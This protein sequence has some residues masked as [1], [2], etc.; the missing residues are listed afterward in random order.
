MGLYTIEMTQLLFFTCQLP[1]LN[2]KVEANSSEKSKNQHD[3]T[4]R[5]STEG[6]KSPCLLL[7]QPRQSNNRGVV[8]VY[9]E[10]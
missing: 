6:T 10:G 2:I 9:H 7:L 4:K 5:R 1:L 8:T 3:L